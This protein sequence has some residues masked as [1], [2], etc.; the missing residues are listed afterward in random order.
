M[1]ESMRER[2]KKFNDGVKPEGA[3]NTRVRCVWK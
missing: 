3:E 1:N 2:N